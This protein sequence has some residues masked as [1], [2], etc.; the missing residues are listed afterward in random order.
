M[1]VTLSD[2]CL[3]DG[4]LLKWV[5]QSNLNLGTRLL[6]YYGNQE[7]QMIFNKEIFMQF[8]KSEN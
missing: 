2:D 6:L 4:Y 5:K 3:N 1:D 7:N 8:F